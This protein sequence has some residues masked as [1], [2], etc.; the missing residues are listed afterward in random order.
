MECKVLDITI[1]SAKD[2]QDV[3]LF[4]KMQVYA[5]VSI[6]DYNLIKDDTCTQITPI[7]KDCGPNP[8]WNFPMKFCVNTFA[9]QLNRLILVVE[10]KADK[11]LG[12]KDIGE[13]QVPVKELLDRFGE[14][15]NEKSVS[16]SV[17]TPSGEAKGL[18]YFT[19]KFS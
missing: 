4:F 13:V 7:D 11:K 5:V 16:Y 18:L 17:I 8:E 10:L 14:S 19:Y 12:N 15:N 6:Q 3:N 9:S 1:N 2:L